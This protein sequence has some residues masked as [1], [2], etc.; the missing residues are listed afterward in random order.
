M[1]NHVIVSIKKPRSR[2][3][4]WRFRNVLGSLEAS[5]AASLLAKIYGVARVVDEVD[6][7]HE[8]IIT[9]EVF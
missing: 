9:L 5:I 8:K 4:S 1:E 2:L 6:R 3:A 7:D